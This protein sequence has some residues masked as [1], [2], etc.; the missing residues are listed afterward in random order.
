MPFILLFAAT[1]MAAD[2][3]E[4]N[5]R[6]RFQCTV[7][8]DKTVA[9][10]EQGEQLAYRFGR[11]GAVELEVAKPFEISRQ[12]TA[13][14]AETHVA[15]VWNEGH[16]YA[17]VVERTED[18]FEGSVVV[19]KGA[20]EVVTLACIDQPAADFTE[21]GAQ[22]AG[23]P[24]RVEAWVGEWAASVGGVTITHHDGAFYLK[25][26]ATWQGMAPGVINVGE[27][28]GVAARA[29]AD[30][31]Q[32]TAGCEVTLLRT[33][34]DQLT[35]TDDYSCGGHNVTFSGEYRRAP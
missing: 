16:R 25:G 33:G 32:Y 29:S 8:G 30:R 24:E 35:A 19:R 3:C 13:A 17:V 4:S 9:L 15:S 28:D 27:L 26:T 10:C 7:R 14:D 5:E 12:S 6:M 21:L 18:Q 20:E 2:L 1:A 11:P 22:Y 34:P 31:L 23:A